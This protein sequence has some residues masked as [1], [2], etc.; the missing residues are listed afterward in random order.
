MSN[1]FSNRRGGPRH[2]R[3]SGGL[4]PNAKPD[5]AAAM[6]RLA[7]T[8]GTASSGDESVFA[9]SRHEQEI[10]RSENIAAGLPAEG[11]PQVSSKPAGR[12]DYREPNLETPEEVNAEEGGEFTPVEVKERPK[13]LMAHLKHAAQKVVTKVKKMMKP[14]VKVHKEVIINSE[15]LETRVA[16]SED[17]RLES[18][19][20][21][22]FEKRAATIPKTPVPGEEVAVLWA[23]WMLAPS[24][25]RPLSPY[26]DQPFDV[27]IRSLKDQGSPA[28]A[29]EYLR[30][31]PKDPDA[32][33]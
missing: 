18:L 4:N 7:A 13:G 14:E 3:P 21:E 24:A 15:S 30:Y 10:R 32:I 2:F 1:R 6:A 33:N 12:H 8:V 27:Y 19:T 11:E 17:G 26:D 16:V 23:K 25:T 20:L 28:A 5:R 31:R 29:R 22:D 9:R